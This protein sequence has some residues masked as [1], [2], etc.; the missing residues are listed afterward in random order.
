MNVILVTEEFFARI[1]CTATCFFLMFMQS[2]FFLAGSKNQFTNGQ[3]M[4]VN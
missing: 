2:I 4:Y 3:F 1:L